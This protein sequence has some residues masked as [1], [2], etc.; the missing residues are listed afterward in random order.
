MATVREFLDSTAGKAASIAL[1]I[2][3]VIAIFLVGKNVFGP[4]ADVAAAN[5]RTFIDLSTMKPFQY[6]LKAGD[7]VPVAAPSGQK[8]GYPAELC[9]WTKDGKVRST[10]Y[11][12]LLNSWKHEAEP[13]FCPDCGRLVTPQNPAPVGTNPTPPP[14]KEEYKP[15]SGNRDRRE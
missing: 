14:T 10:P 12:V 2:V 13:T 3:G 8:A 1:I 6:E 4:S 11:P 5:S 15:D 7:S 9:W